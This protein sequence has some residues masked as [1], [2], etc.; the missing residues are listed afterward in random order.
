MTNNQRTKEAVIFDEWR[1]LNT[2]S[3]GKSELVMINAALVRKF[4]AGGAQSPASIARLL[5]DHGARLRHPE[6]LDADA[7]WREQQTDLLFASGEIDFTTMA[8]SLESVT[9][10]DELYSQF[11]AESDRD[12]AQQLKEFARDWKT[13]LKRP[14]LTSLAEEVTEWLT[15]WLQTP[16][17]FAEWLD[18]RLKSPGFKAKFGSQL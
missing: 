2:E 14:P 5:A 12:G 8:R 15:I 1:S 9:R 7:Q 13:E 4:G 3:V 18:L 17:M 10:L 6:V 16:Q 11:L